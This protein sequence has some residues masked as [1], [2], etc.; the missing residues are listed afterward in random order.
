MSSEMARIREDLEFIK[1]RLL[2]IEDM[3]HLLINREYEVR[4]EYVDKIKRI[5]SEDEFEEYESVGE[6]RKAI[7]Q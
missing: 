4:D 1:N 7:E 2:E 5:L 6:L 3:F